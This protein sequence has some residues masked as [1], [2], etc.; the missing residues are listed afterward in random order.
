[1]DI[2]DVANVVKDVC[3]KH[4]ST[5]AVDSSSRRR[6]LSDAKPGRLVSYALKCKH[7]MKNRQA[8]DVT[9]SVERSTCFKYLFQAL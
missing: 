5:L 1:M 8:A 7:G 9:A 3:S 4:G 2:V 6:S